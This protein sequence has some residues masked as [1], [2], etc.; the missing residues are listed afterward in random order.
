MVSFVCFQLDGIYWR[1]RNYGTFR[2]EEKPLI[3]ERPSDGSLL[4]FKTAT[5]LILLWDK[6]RRN[7]RRMDG[8]MEMMKKQRNEEEVCQREYSA[9]FVCRRPKTV[10]KIINICLWFS[11]SGDF[12]MFC[13]FIYIFV[14]LFVC[15]FVCL[16]LVYLSI[17]FT[18]LFVCLCS[19]VYYL[20]L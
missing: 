12:Q 9:I 2:C 7:T 10:K 8:A 15:L 11:F 14:Y 18:Y 5:C 6:K 19:F 17:L 1:R 4:V 20:F 16:L 13:P 3:T